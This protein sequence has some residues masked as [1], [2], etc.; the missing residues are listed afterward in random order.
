MHGCRRRL[1]YWKTK[2]LQVDIWSYCFSCNIKPTDS[3]SFSFQIPNKFL[4]WVRDFV[5][6]GMIGYQAYLLVSISVLWNVMVCKGFRNGLIRKN[7]F[8][9]PSA[10]KFFLHSFFF[11]TNISWRS[12]SPII[13]VKS[14]LRFSGKRLRHFRNRHGFREITKKYEREISPGV[15]VMCEEVGFK[16]H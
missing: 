4:F 3:L 13:L 5:G 1:H 15:S 12:V 16:P 8:P 6:T 11:I 7:Y 2:L 14:V 9:T 10:P